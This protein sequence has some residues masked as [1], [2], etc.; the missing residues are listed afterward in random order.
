MSSN[1]ESM[2]N[3]MVRWNATP[4]VKAKTPAA[5]TSETILEDEDEDEDD[6]EDETSPWPG[7][8]RSDSTDQQKGRPR[9]S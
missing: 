1:F 9:D 7:S 6:L 2:V 8:D 3:E 4:E 5:D